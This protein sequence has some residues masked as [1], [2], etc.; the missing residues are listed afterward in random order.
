MYQARDMPTDPL[1]ARTG[2][3]ATRPWGPVR[4]AVST[5]CTS[6]PANNRRGEMC[7]EA[8]SKRHGA[9]MLMEGTGFALLAC[10]TAHPD[11]GA[12]LVAVPLPIT[13][14]RERLH[15]RC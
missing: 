5:Q 12:E 3:A 7:I 11:S 2:A 8:E 4:I 14:A 10:P 9:R 13:N 6:G 1:V 15:S